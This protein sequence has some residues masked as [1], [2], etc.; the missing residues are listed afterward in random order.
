[1]KKTTTF[2]AIHIK[3]AHYD[4]ITTTKI[5]INLSLS[6]FYD[7]CFSRRKKCLYSELF[8]S[9]FSRI[10]TRTTPNT[11]TFYAVAKYLSRYT[12]SA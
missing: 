4:I 7:Q 11:D 12:L 5:L 3:K 1:M 6:W 2:V 10:R 9:V 8:W